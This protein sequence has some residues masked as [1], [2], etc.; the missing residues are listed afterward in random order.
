MAYSR[1]R[2]TSYRGGGTVTTM[3][4]ETHNIG[5]WDMMIAFP[6]CTYMSA[7]G[8]CRMYPRKGE[9]DADRFRKAQEAKRFFDELHDADIPCI[10]IENPKPLK[11]VGLPDSTQ[12]IQPYQFGEPYSKR[13]CLWLKNLFPLKPTETLTEYKPFVSCGTSRNKG[14]KDKAGYSRAGGAQIV[15]SRTFWGIARAMAEQWG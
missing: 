3:D 11:V 6:P 13:T 10:A 7:A 9:I 12:T 15:R 1:G 4:G 14:N 8:A 2:I 5:K